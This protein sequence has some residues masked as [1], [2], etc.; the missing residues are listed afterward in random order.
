MSNVWF[1]EMPSDH[2]EVIVLYRDH[3]VD[4]GYYE[5]D[6]G[7]HTVQMRQD[8]IGWIPI[9]SWMGTSGDVDNHD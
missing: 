5:T 4:T 8:V 6:A 7:W 2:V 3:S 9:T 1:T